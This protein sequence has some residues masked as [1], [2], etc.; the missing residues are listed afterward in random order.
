VWDVS[1][2]VGPTLLSGDPTLEQTQ[3]RAI[4]RAMPRT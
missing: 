3:I 2:A 1:V 4:K